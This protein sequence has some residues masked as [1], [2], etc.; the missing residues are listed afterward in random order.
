MLNGN[1]GEPLALE[2]LSALGRVY[3][4]PPLLD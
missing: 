4:W 1:G 2:I 3:G